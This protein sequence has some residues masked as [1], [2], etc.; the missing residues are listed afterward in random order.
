MCVREGEGGE[1]GG[2]RN[3]NGGIEVKTAQRPERDDRPQDA[4]DICAC[5]DRYCE[6]FFAADA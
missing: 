6:G 3:G 5:S 4:G 2:C 1:I